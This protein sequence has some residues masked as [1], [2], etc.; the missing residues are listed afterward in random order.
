MIVGIQPL[1]KKAM[2]CIQSLE[3]YKSRI[4]EALPVVSGFSFGL[5]IFL[6]LGTHM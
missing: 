5:A 1:Q 6:L 3:H 2:Y 4:S